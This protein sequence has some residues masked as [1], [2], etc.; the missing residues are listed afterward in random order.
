MNNYASALRRMS[1][2][3]WQLR[4]QSRLSGFAWSLI[5]PVLAFVVL[6]FVFSRWLGPSTPDY[7]ARLLVGVL[8]W[9]FFS[10]C[11]SYGLTSLVRRAALLRNFSMPLE[12]PVLS[13]VASAAATHFIEMLLLCVYL[14][15]CGYRPQ[16]RWLLALPAE[17]VLIALAAGASLVL[18]WLAAVYRDVERIWAI[19]VSA[20][21]FLTPVFYDPTLL[22][23]GRRSILR[24]NPL[25]SVL[26][27]TR[28]ALVGGECSLSELAWAMCAAAFL[29]ALGLGLLRRADG[30]ARDFLY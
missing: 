22:D 20:G 14:A 1:L 12:V 21:F 17:A 2:C 6:S 25:T 18:A 11:T 10:A 28:A 9:G 26:A 7:R 16:A 13:S 8:Q 27:Q 3:E 29:A 24:W 15:V 23:G 30:R 19:A 5:Q 4:S